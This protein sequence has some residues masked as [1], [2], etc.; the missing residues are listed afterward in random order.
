MKKSKTAA[1][2][3]ISNSISPEDAIRFLEDIRLMSVH[4]DEP[5]VAI[6]LRVPGNILRALKLKAKSDG[7]KY[8]SLIIEYLRKGLSDR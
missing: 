6:S 3:K 5:T 1:P 8:Q 2:K 7:K 4:L